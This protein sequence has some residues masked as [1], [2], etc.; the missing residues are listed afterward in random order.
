MAVSIRN[1]LSKALRLEK[2]L[3]ERQDVADELTA[4]EDHLDKLADEA[5]NEIYK[6]MNLPK[7]EIELS[8]KKN[9]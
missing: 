3:S 6:E 2:R 4:L 8:P 5:I 7:I 1:G 9:K